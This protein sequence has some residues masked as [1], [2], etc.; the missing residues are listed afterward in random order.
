MVL[1][2]RGAGTFTTAGYY[3]ILCRSL[4]GLQVVQDGRS[5]LRLALQR[6]RATSAASA[7]ERATSAA[8]AQERATYFQDLA[9]PVV[10][11]LVLVAMCKGHSRK[12]TMWESTFSAQQL[13]EWIE[14]AFAVQRPRV[15]FTKA[16]PTSQTRQQHL[17]YNACRVP[18]EGLP[19]NGEGK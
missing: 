7:Q 8:S 9:P 19:T 17:P 10:R 4:F 12:T 5:R 6:K 13:L 18:P 11:K 14:E 1:L 16:S 3:T 2:P 15:V